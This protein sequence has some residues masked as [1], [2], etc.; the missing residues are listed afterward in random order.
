M[1]KIII[2]ERDNVGVCLENIND[3]PIGHK[4][5]LSDVKKG[6]FIIKYGEIIGRATTDIKKGEWVH[7]H[8]LKSHLDEDFLF[9]YDFSANTPKKQTLTFKGYKRD[10]KRNR[11]EHSRKLRI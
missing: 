7:T 8:N 5:A 6:D 1:K 4:Y 10:C 2:N 9:K 11:L 3:I